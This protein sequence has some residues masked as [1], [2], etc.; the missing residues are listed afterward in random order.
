LLFQCASKL[1]FCYF[2]FLGEY[3]SYE[4]LFIKSVSN[5]FCSCYSFFYEY[6]PYLFTSLIKGFIQL[7]LSNC[8]FI[9]KYFT[10]EILFR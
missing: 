8:A 3:F 1:E 2:T 10:Q 4:F 7:I 5:L 9:Q 6:F